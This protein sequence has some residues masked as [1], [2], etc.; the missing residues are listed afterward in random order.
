[1]YFRG[2]VSLCVLL[3]E[4]FDLAQDRLDNHHVLYILHFFK[5]DLRSK[6]FQG[7]GECFGSRQTEVLFTSS[8]EER[9]LQQ[10]V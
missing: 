4:L 10:C 9:Y 2:C 8:D 7:S 6:V 5:V 1:M 3:E